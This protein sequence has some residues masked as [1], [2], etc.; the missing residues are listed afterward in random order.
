MLPFVIKIATQ[1]L[2]RLYR[3]NDEHQHIDVDVQIELYSR[4]IN[5][6]QNHSRGLSQQIFQEATENAYLAF[7][8][9]LQ[10]AAQPAE[11]L[12]F[13][14]LEQYPSCYYCLI[15]SAAR[16]HELWEICQMRRD[17]SRSLFQYRGYELAIK[18]RRSVPDTTAYLVSPEKYTLFIR[19]NR[20]QDTIHVYRSHFMNLTGNMP[21]PLILNAGEIIEAFQLE[22]RDREERALPIEQLL[23]FPST[24]EKPHTSRI[25]KC[26]I[27]RGRVK[28][29]G[30]EGHFCLECDWDDLPVLTS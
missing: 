16:A 7:I 23:M 22:F 9:F 26:P 4:E 10:N 6:R 2:E 18:A 29:L 20:A 8:T 11:F 15:L 21:P 12:P 5:R 13:E 14:M 28:P 19:Q 27:C 3:I 24:A 25:T 30:K 1:P 17:V